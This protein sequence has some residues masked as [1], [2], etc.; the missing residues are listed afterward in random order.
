MIMQSKNG[1]KDSVGGGKW[2][3]RFTKLVTV[4]KSHSSAAQVLNHG[5]FSQ[6][7][8]TSGIQ[9]NNEPPTCRTNL[10][11]GSELA[12]TSTCQTGSEQEV[13]PAST[14]TVV[15]EP[16]SQSSSREVDPFTSTRN[17]SDTLWQ[18]AV[19]S[20][21]TQDPEVYTEYHGILSAAVA[22]SG[23]ENPAQMLDELMKAKKERVEDDR[24]VIEAF[25]KSFKVKSLVTRII[26]TL[27][28]LRTYIAT[29][30]SSGSDPSFS[31]ACTGICLLLS[32]G[33][34]LSDHVR[35]MISAS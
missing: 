13:S 20:L 10:D 26:S 8:T 25:G 11:E 35:N 14:S 9:E 31:L 5:N 33:P 1:A 19:T 27:G 30:G 21:Q 3:A 6:N 28:T 4:T 2:K 32:V 23:S 7:H 24:W 16:R 22:T 15:N 18:R 29:A 17:D 34:H 12:L